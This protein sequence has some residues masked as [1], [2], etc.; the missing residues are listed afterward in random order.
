MTL[1]PFI[2]FLTDG[3]PATVSLKFCYITV[4]HLRIQEIFVP[5]C[6]N[7]PLVALAPG[8]VTS[9]SVL[10]ECFFPLPQVPLVLEEVP[11]YQRQQLLQLCSLL[12][13]SA[14]ISSPYVGL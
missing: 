6:K 12:S 5:L 8:L 1:D 10:L 3:N 2:S 9:S 4:G 14:C 13:V 11:W 7:G